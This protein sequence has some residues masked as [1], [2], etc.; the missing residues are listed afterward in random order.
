[1]PALYCG[2]VYGVIDQTPFCVDDLDVLRPLEESL[3]MYQVIK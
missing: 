2:G 1:M 3:R